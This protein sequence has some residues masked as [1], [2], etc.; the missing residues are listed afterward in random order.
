MKTTEIVLL[1]LGSILFV[2]SI[3]MMVLLFKK[4]KPF[5]KIIWFLVL[6]FLMMGF[7]VIKEANVAGIFTYQK[8][9]ELSELGVLTDALV[10]CPNNKVIK[11]ELKR[12]L[13]SYIEH[14]EDQPKQ[15]EELEKI[16]NAYLLLGDEN[17]AISV[18]E[19][20][21]SKDTMN[22]TARVL[23]K[24]AITQNL[25]KALPA[26]S[27]KKEVALQV[28]KRIEALQNDPNANVEQIA[29]LR[30]M[31]TKATENII[32]TTTKDY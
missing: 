13:T 17:K 31:Y 22:Q 15:P 3:I 24:V 27:D 23:R 32:D 21:L 7:S 12:K 6:S 16:G 8:Q 5:I 2:F 4:D 30:K 28:K 1:L 18:S 29:H 26:E 20:A 9:E 25:I 19:E 14:V 11:Q 10:E